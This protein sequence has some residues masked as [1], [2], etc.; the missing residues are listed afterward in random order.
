[1]FRGNYGL[2]AVAWQTSSTPTAK[3]GEPTP[4]LPT[5]WPGPHVGGL[6]GALA[7]ADARL[8]VGEGDRLTVYD[9]ASAGAE[10]SPLASVILPNVV[11]DIAYEQG[12]AYVVTGP[13][14]FQVA[15]VAAGG[16]R[17]VGSMALP[18]WARS[19]AVAEGRAYV[20]AEAG[21][22]RVVDVSQ[23]S[24]PVELGSVQGEGRFTAVAA[25]PPYAYLADQNAT[26]S[27]ADVSDPH[28][29][30][31]VYSLD[32]GST[33]LD[34]AVEGGRL[35]LAT[36]RGLQVFSLADPV[37][38]VE[39][40]RYP[41]DAR[42]SLYSLALA[43]GRVFVGHYQ[44]GV[45][46]FR[47]DAQ[48]QPTP[49]CPPCPSPYPD[50]SR[51]NVV[52]LVA[53]GGRVYVADG[54]AWRVMEYGAMLGS[55]LRPSPQPSPT[56]RGG[57]TWETTANRTGENAC[58]VTFCAGCSRRSPSC[59]A[60]P[61]WSSPWFTRRPAARWPSSSS[62]PPSSR[63]TSPASAP[64]SASTA[65]S[66]STSRPVPGDGEAVYRFDRADPL[67]RSPPAGRSAGQRVSPPMGHGFWRRWM[68]RCMPSN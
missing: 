1:M 10:Q 20:A 44:T 16:T 49:V 25:R 14:G 53:G 62:I 12:R 5:L 38:P 19:V 34:L 45:E 50:P 59:L 21:G 36:T 31:L 4:T 48:G 58:R 23:P 66:T 41:Q 61:S 35:Y 52:A 68:M 9:A 55:R 27:V 6:I 15:D 13:G 22:L 3:L 32:N 56:G 28:A 60:S 26:L 63:R 7:L 43:D 17:L 39:V 2:K 37:Q 33:A 29:P 30:R 18:G 54:D 46:E 64:T 47:V 67:P 42:Y 57:Q 40:G 24:Q 8:L 51:A 65:R 11:Q